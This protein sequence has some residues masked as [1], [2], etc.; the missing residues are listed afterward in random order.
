MS[1][2]AG[3][4]GRQESAD[5]VEKLE[6]LGALKIPP[7]SMRSDFSRS[8]PSWISSGGFRRIFGQT[9]WPPTSF[10]SCWLQGAAKFRSVAKKEFFNIG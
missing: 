10:L 9:C 1:P 3:G 8:M 2:I 5:S 4:A 7:N 6:K